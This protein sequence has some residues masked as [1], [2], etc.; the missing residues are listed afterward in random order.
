M[1]VPGQLPADAW[2]RGQR[3]PVGRGWAQAIRHG[4]MTVEQV[5]ARG[6]SQMLDEEQAER[7]RANPFTLVSAP[8]QR[9]LLSRLLRR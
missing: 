6:W 2:M 9:N 4:P 1:N 5:L 3:D 8:P 7:E